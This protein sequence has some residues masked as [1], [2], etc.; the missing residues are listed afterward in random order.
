M[1]TMKKFPTELKEW[2][3]II[4]RKAKRAGLD[5]FEVIFE[6]VNFDQMNEFAA[7]GGF[8]T[9]W[10]HWSFGQAYEEHRKFYAHGL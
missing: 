3:Y 5:P 7:Y 1:G 2:K 4:E 10:A 8:P 6:M 9:R